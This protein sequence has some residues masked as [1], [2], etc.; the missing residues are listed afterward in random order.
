MNFRVLTQKYM[1]WCPGVESAARFI[2]DRDVND[3]A[4]GAAF[5]M[6]MLYIIFLSA[7]NGIFR[8]VLMV[9]TAFIGAPAVWI[10]FRGDKA[11]GQEHTYPDQAVRPTPSEK[12]GTF[13]IDGPLAEAPVYGP[14]RSSL[15]YYTDMTIARE[16]LHPDIFDMRKMQAERRRKAEEKEKP[17]EEEKKTE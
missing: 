9:F 1:G 2:P 3:K 6:L 5:I 4:V 17:E 11:G 10:I 14:T 8:F 7:F 15:D 16:W 13:K 12:F